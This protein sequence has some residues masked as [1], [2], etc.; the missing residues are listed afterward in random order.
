MEWTDEKVFQ[1]IKLYETQPCLYDMLCKEYHNRNKKKQ[2]CV[3][4]DSSGTSDDW[5]VL[6]DYG[7]SR[8]TIQLIKA[9]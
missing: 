5:S 8:C 7:D 2:A 6:N 4:Q 1:L 9:W 3:G